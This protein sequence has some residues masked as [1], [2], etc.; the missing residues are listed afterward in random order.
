MRKI[1]GCLGRIV[2]G[3]V[4]LIAIAVAFIYVRSEQL[5]SQTFHAPEVMITVPT[6]AASIERG[7]HLAT[8]I[9]DCTGC[10]GANFAGTVVIDDP[11][12]GRI[13]SA[14]VTKGKDGVGGSLS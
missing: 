12:L 9:S 6:D 2:L 10:H 11:A 14:N 8:V 3:V 13:V 4:V 7:H 1:L 5:V